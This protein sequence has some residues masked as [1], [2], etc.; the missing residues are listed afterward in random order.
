[1]K[2]PSFLNWSINLYT[3]NTESCQTLGQLNRMK[4]S[5]KMYQ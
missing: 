2:P 5:K 4:G 3:C 1:M